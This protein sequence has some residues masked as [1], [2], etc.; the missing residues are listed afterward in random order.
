MNP[1]KLDILITGQ[2]K[3]I[4]RDEKDEIF[5]GLKIVKGAQIFHA[6]ILR[7]PEGNG[8]GFQDIVEVKP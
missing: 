3:Q 7:D 6:W 2:V 8:P 5:Y 4:I 1:E